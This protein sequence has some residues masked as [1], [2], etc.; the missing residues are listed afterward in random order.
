[1]NCQAETPAARATTNS[2]FRDRLRN[3]I[4]VPKRI[5]KGRACS[6][7]IGVC[8]SE[9]HAIK[10]PVAA[11]VSPERRE[12]IFE[13]FERGE[14][15][16]G[17]FEGSG[18][19]LAISRRLVDLMGGSLALEDRPGGGSVFAFTVPLP[20]CEDPAHEPGPRPAAL[21]G[22]R[23]LIIAN[24][25]FEAP[26]IAMRLAEAGAAVTRADGLESGLAALA[27][28][29]RPDLV[30]VDCALGP[31]ATNRLALA[32]RGAGAPK[33]LVLFSPF[34]R[35]AFG[36]TALKGFDGWLVKPV[37]ARS[38]YERLAAEFHG[39][40][41]VAGGEVR[42][43]ESRRALIAEDNDINALIAEK[44]LRRLGFEPVRAVD[45]E[46]AV[47]IA[48]PGGPNSVPFDLILM[49]LQMPGVDGL[50]ATRR[51]R[52]REAALGVRR[53]PIVAL[54]ANG[55]D[56]ERRSCGAA[57]FDAFLVKPFEFEGLSEAIRRVCGSLPPQGLPKAS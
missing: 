40:P 2:S 39:G 9:S 37:R 21:A 46:E 45:G 55:F 11:G 24:S 41:P 5:T 26:A 22:V 19:G 35:R 25:P 51:L 10:S 50:E 7:K 17:R 31:E 56:D 20:A 57:G 13:D 53:T 47:R 8:R 33:S 23:A 1:M 14:G 36:E 30:I 32:A 44:A 54:T 3:E 27:R 34:E 18:L 4:I 43:T 48:E 49:D 28:A 52:R 12:S 15:S 16:R 38:L 42:R 6:A 29:E